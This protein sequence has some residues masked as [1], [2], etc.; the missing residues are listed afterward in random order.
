M[1]YLSRAQWGA[2][3]STSGHTV[4]QAQF[5]RLV[6]HHTVMPFTAGDDIIGYMRRLQ[7][8]RPDLGDDVPYSFVVFPT[9]NDLDFVVAE[10]RGWFRT[11]A[12]TVGYNSSAYGV[13]LPGNFQDAQPT[14]GQLMGIRWVG[15]K[16]F[17]PAYALPTLGHR[18]V[19]RT[20]CPG[21]HMYQYM[22]RIQP[23][24]ITEEV[25]EP[26]AITAEDIEAIAIAVWNQKIETARGVFPA[27]AVAGWTKDE[28]TEQQNLVKRIVDAIVPHLVSA[29]VAGDIVITDADYIAKAVVRELSARLSS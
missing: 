1:I 28:V 7:D 6:I 24:F 22:D 27:R 10:G 25:E 20:A 13:A 18:D 29:E 11:G 3:P 8:V 23:S 19:Y 21:D 15:S 16:L 17:N 2:H 5:N 26:V 14:V 12:H 4:P 9:K